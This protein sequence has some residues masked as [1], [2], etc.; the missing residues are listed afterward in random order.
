M[1]RSDYVL[2]VEPLGVGHSSRTFRQ[3]PR[4]PLVVLNDLKTPK[5]AGKHQ[6]RTCSYPSR[7]V[8]DDKAFPNTYYTIQNNKNDLNWSG[9]LVAL[10]PEMDFGNFCRRR[11]WTRCLHTCELP[12]LHTLMRTSV[13]PKLNFGTCNIAPMSDKPTPDDMADVV[14]SLDTSQAAPNTP[15]LKLEESEIRNNN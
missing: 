1:I 15:T 12:H 2:D 4:A 13:W 3:R 7:N 9:T 14:V 11:R 8:A 5:L 10:F 6:I